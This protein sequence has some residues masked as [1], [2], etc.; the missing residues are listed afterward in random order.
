MNKFGKN[1][2][3]EIFG[4]SHSSKIGLIMSNLPKGLTIDLD[5]INKN[6]SFR[7]GDDSISTPR[8][9]KDQLEF[10]SG[11]NNGIT[12]GENLKII[13]E[14]TDVQDTSFD[15][16]IRPGH[17]DLV[18]YLRYNEYKQGGGLSS[19]RMTTLLVVAGTICQQILNKEGFIAK[20]FIRQIG[21]IKDESIFNKELFQR[22]DESFSLIDKKIEKS[23]IEEI[24]RAQANKNSLGGIVESYINC[25]IK[26]LGEPFFD[27][28]ESILSHLIFSIPGIN[29]IEFGEGFNSTNLL[30]SEY[31][32]SIYYENDEINYKTNHQGGL[33]GGMTN[34]NIINFK[35]SIRPTS[36][37]G[38]TQD[39]I[40]V[41]TKK[42]SQI[43]IN[44]RNDSCFVHRALH[45]INACCYIVLYDL[46]LEYNKR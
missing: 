12:N 42:N 22:A 7:K 30:G 20:S 15:G 2:T 40:N 28:F 35:I 38:I 41:L 8:R 44:S 33:S 13:I 21:K 37:I 36:S 4:E 17:A 23:M 39:T 19:G 32:D 11:I 34:G 9:E 29:G 24:Q 43:T 3:I 18:N 16:N 14:N 31:N 10:V 46:L 1:I 25:P 26:T 27:S 45:V 5:L 6:L